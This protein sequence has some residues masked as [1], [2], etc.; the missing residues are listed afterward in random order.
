MTQHR[1]VREGNIVRLQRRC[2]NKPGYVWQN[3]M[4]VHVAN[5]IQ[6]AA[7]KDAWEKYG[8]VYLP[9]NPVKQHNGFMGWWKNKI[10]RI[11]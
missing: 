4:P 2:T 11:S 6:A 10:A 5:D 8:L 7:V 9:E 1:A 3:A